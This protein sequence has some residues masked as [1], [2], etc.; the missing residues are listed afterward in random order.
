MAGMGYGATLVA[1]RGEE[2]LVE[3]DVVG[4]DGSSFRLGPVSES[5][6]GAQLLQRIAQLV[7]KVAGRVRVQN[8][9]EA[10]S[11]QKT[12]KEQDLVGESPCV[13]Y[14]YEPSSLQD[15]WNLLQGLPADDPALR[16]L[17]GISHMEGVEAARLNELRILPQSL[18]SLSFCDHLNQCQMEHVQ[19]PSGLQRLVLGDGFNKRLDHV[20]WPSSLCSLTLSASFNQTVEGV[21]SCWMIGRLLLHLPRTWIA[22][23]L[24]ST[25]LV[26]HNSRPVGWPQGDQ[27]CSCYC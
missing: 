27:R 12:L 16:A 10:L 17:E 14:I 23:M 2:R 8:G 1:C 4:L 20:A 21:R 7:P 26:R 9:S 18:R 3:I 19:W 11:L 24:G 22:G 6:T 25:L 5:L 15:A 13:S